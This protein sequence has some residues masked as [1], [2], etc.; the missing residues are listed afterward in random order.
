M[1]HFIFKICYIPTIEAGTPIN[2]N[3]IMIETFPIFNTRKLYYNSNI[4][5]VSYISLRGFQATFIL[6]LSK[7]ISSAWQPNNSNT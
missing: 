6:A 2:I 7:Q 3:K 5:S 4:L 1:I